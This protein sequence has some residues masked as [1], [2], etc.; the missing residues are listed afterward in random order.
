MPNEINGLN[1]N[2]IK[3]LNTNKKSH[4][5]ELEQRN[6]K[7]GN[8]SVQLKR[9]DQDVKLTDTAAKLRQIEANIANQ[10]IVDT[11]RVERIKKAIA[12]GTHKVDSS[13]TASKMMEFENLLASKAGDK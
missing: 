6:L 5:D 2:P 7:T 12:D 8:S 3:S 10:P 13:R 4:S 11:Q 1:I 9:T